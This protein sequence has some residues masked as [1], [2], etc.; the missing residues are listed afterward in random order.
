MG[1]ENFNKSKKIDILKF[2][3]AV[4]IYIEKNN[5]KLIFIDD[6]N[7]NT[8]LFVHLRSGDFGVVEDNFIKIVKNVSQNYKNIYILCG[9]HKGGRGDINESKQN[10]VNSINKIIENNH[11]KFKVI[12]NEPD[13]HLSIFRKC[14]NLLLHR[15]GFSGLGYI[16]FKGNKLYLNNEIY[17]LNTIYPEIN[18]NNNNNNIEII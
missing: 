3:N 14:K 16:L 6:L 9:I 11:D 2:Q 12:I 5:D 17:N 10:L 1:D 7:K 15:G 8:S 13:I 4:D 18:N